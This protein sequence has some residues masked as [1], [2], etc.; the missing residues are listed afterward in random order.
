MGNLDL[1]SYEALLEESFP[2]EISDKPQSQTQVQHRGLES[3]NK[4]RSLILDGI[5]GWVAWSAILIVVV[6][7]LFSPVFVFT[8][9][10]IA[11]TYMAGRFAMA[12]FLALNG[13]IRIQKAQKVNWRTEYDRLRRA[14]SLVWE[15]VIHTVIIPNY[16]EDYTVLYDTLERIAQSPLAKT[17]VCVILGMEEREKDAAA[18][19]E[20]LTIAFESRFL[21]IITTFHP[22]DIAGE[23]AGKSSNE[24][25]AA[26]EAYKT[27]VVGHGYDIN[28]MVITIMDADSLIHPHY[29]EAVTCQFATT[30]VQN[31][32]NSMWQAPIRYDN[33]IWKVHPF[34]TFI[35]AY[36]TAWYLSGL[37]GRHPMPLSTYSLSFRMAHEVGYW[38]T[39]VIPEDWH[40]YIKCYFKRHGNLQLHPIYLPFSG[41]S[42]AVGETFIDA[43]RSQYA[44]SVR[45]M[46][47]AEDV[48]YI[49]DQSSKHQRMPILPQLTIFWR[50]FHN[51]ALSTTGW[52]ITNLGVQLAL[53]VYPS[54]NYDPIIGTQMA[55]LHAVIQIII[56]VSLLFWVIDLRM[57]PQKSWTISEMIMTII[58]FII[59]PFTTV[60]MTILP[61]LE[62]QTRLMLGIPIHYRVARKV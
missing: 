21:H 41:Y 36:S 9:S 8:L 55:I 12:G 32:F 13:V 4:S 48:G 17:N 24:A 20:S 40:M 38:D 5:T 44:Q 52:V 61:A 15:D 53:L 43:V 46:W 26:R 10:A 37:S 29:L 42:A 50:V 3:I 62:A 22:K 14:D 54:L 23:V 33:N 11:G 57:R 59:M 30:P 56:S 35:H 16:K 47:G 31:R 45:H 6:G 60:F 58:S 25:W 49:L 2:L 39:D 27:L 34:F 1:L 28:Q 7:A 19:A 51:H 18:K